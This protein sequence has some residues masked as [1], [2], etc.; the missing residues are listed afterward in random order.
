MW[1]IQTMKFLIVV[2]SPFIW[3]PFE[4]KMTKLK[5][6]WTDYL[7]HLRIVQLEYHEHQEFY[8]QFDVHQPEHI[9]AAFHPGRND[10]LW[11]VSMQ[12]WWEQETIA[13]PQ[14]TIPV[15][16]SRKTE[17]P[18]LWFTIHYPVAA[19]VGYNDE[20]E[21]ILIYFTDLFFLTNSTIKGVF[22]YVFFVRY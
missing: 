4:L 17:G 22:K 19:R 1:T 8:K 13:Q 11:L 7:W 21:E 9:V 6:S 14:L 10:P 15:W 5:Y 2:H 16:K 18:L 12:N 20:T 3:I